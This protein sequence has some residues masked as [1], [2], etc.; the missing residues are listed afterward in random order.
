[1]KHNRV[2][3][4]SVWHVATK[5]AAV[6]FSERGMSNHFFSDSRDPSYVGSATCPECPTKGCRGKPRWL[7]PWE[8]RSE[9]VQGLCGVNTSPTL[10]DLVWVWSQQ[11]Y[12]KLLLT[13]S[14]RAVSPVTL[15]GGKADMKM[16]EWNEA[17][18][19]RFSTKIVK[20][21]EKTVEILE[22]IGENFCIRFVKQS[23]KICLY[24]FQLWEYLEASFNSVDFVWW[25][26]DTW[27]N[28]LF[29]QPL[30]LF[31]LVLSSTKM[32]QCRKIWL[33]SQLVQL[34]T[35]NDFQYFYTPTFR[36]FCPIMYT[37][38]S[39]LTTR[40]FK[41]M[42]IYFDLCSIWI[43]KYLQKTFMK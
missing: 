34:M 10:L 1:M 22:F 38:G 43:K 24:S 42:K 13:V 29:F 5:F 8:S 26:F 40:P 7:N 30:R 23:D 18:L 39:F 35:T 17:A 37:Q 15:L 21:V 14:A 11:D 31:L 41:K 32:G 16:K 36:I 6:K 9:V 33:Y 19:E 3:H 20:L 12:L 27:W 28:Y 4:A 2:A 25:Q